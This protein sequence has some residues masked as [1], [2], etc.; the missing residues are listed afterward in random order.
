MRHAN[1]ELPTRK[2]NRIQSKTPR[3]D[4]YWCSC[5]RDMTVDGQ[6][7]GTCGAKRNAHRGK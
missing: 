7:C 4:V 1:I 6:E 2:R 3:T 5:D